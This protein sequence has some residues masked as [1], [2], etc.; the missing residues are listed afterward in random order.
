M[1][2]KKKGKTAFTFVIIKYPYYYVKFKKLSI[3]NLTVYNVSSATHQMQHEIYEFLL[4][5]N[6]LWSF[7]YLKE[8]WSQQRRLGEPY[9]CT[10]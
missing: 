7:P 6:K 1:P 5:F 4:T 3:E 2:R 8:T 9:F 10:L